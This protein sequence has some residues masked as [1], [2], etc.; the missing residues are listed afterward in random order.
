MLVRADP[1]AQLESVYFHDYRKRPFDVTCIFEL[2]T[3]SRNV[4][5][6]TRNDKIYI[7]LNFETVRVKE[8]VILEVV[9]IGPFRSPAIHFGKPGVF[10]WEKVLTYPEIVQEFKYLADVPDHRFYFSCINREFR[11]WLPYPRELAETRKVGPKCIKNEERDELY[12][13]NTQEVGRI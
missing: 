10:P 2:K 13:E 7:S 12:S 6:F 11:L 5:Y 8:G 4:K 1:I 9:R 3:N